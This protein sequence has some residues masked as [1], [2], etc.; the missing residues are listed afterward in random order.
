MC[1]KLKDF[2]SAAFQPLL[3]QLCNIFGRRWIYL[4]IVAIFTLGSGICGGATNGGMLIAGRA[5]QGLGSGG[6]IMMTSMPTMFAIRLLTL[7]KDRNLDIIVSDLVPLRQR[8]KYIA[9]ILAIFGVGVALGPFI[10]GAIVNSTTWRWVFYLNLPIGGASLL[11]MF[12]F[13]HVNYNREMSFKQKIKRIDLIGN[14]ILMA[15]AVAI[16]YALTYAGTLYPWSSWHTLVPLLLGLLGFVLFAEYEVGGFAAEP[17]MPIRLFAN[18]TSIVVIL[19]TFLN[20]V[21]YFWYLYF[22]PVYFQTVALF[23]APR[24]GYSLL[25]QAIAGIPGAAIAA[26]LLSKYGKFKPIHF[27]GFAI[28][29]LGMGLLSLQHEGTAIAAWA[30]FQCVTALGI[31]IIIDTML[32][33]FQA[34]VAETDQAAATAAWSFVRAFGSIWGVAIPAAIFN[35]RVDDLLGTVSDIG[36]RRL[37]ANG[38]AYQQSSASFVRQYDI[39]VQAEIRALYRE[40]LKRVFL[41]GIAFGGLA[42][43]LVLLEREVPLRQELETEY[44]LKPGEQ[45]H[46]DEDEEQARNGRGVKAGAEGDVHASPA[47]N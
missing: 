19:N 41:I 14:A 42:T 28:T 40:A 47:D 23:S 44:G 8:G 45:K 13:L 31:G 22:L 21:L 43:L 7:I 18:W 35:N 17:V 30:A 9:M 2:R 32:P 16:L 39:S 11:T 24:T 10:G 20:S 29:T 15:S 38:G 25:P 27:A 12:I 34:P 46:L 33:A 4:T 5:I 36:A 3:G 1:R 26:I 37:L 6:I